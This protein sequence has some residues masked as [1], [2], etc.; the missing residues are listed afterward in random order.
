MWC[1]SKE[2]VKSGGDR[3][4]MIHPL[5]SSMHNLLC[6]CFFPPPCFFGRI[7]PGKSWMIKRT[8]RPVFLS[9]CE[10][11]HFFPLPLWL[12]SSVLLRMAHC[13]GPVTQDSGR[14]VWTAS[15]WYFHRHVSAGCP[16]TSSTI[17]LTTWSV[18][19]CHPDLKILPSHLFRTPPLH[20]LPQFYTGSPLSTPLNSSSP[21]PPFSSKPNLVNC[22]GVKSP[23]SFFQFA[24][25]PSFFDF[26]CL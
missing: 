4:R 15:A 22:R 14:I 9:I 2:T 25:P 12:V 11:L 13:R 8:G 17:F 7:S 3:P 5:L 10:V 24:S 20:Q 6:H 16:P 18:K 21:D 1:F 23:L 26:V 19:F